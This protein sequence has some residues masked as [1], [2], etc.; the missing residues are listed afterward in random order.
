VEKTVRSIDID[1]FRHN[2]VTQRKQATLTTLEYF[3]PCINGVF[4]YHHLIFYGPKFINEN[5]RPKKCSK[6]VTLIRAGKGGSS[7]SPSINTLQ[8]KW[9]QQCAWK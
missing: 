5:L 6:H 3:L 8:L 4:T 1:L 7:K 2:K 9:Q